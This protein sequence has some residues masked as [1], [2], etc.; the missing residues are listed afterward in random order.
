LNKNLRQQFG[1]TIVELL[2]VIVVIGILAA[3][4]IVAYNGISGRAKVASIQSDLEGSGKQLAIDQVTSGAYP[5]TIAAANGGNGL[6][7]SSGSTYSYVVNN[8]TSPQSYCLSESNGAISYYT[9]STNSVQALG[10]CTTS[11]GL[12]G[13]WPMNGNANDSSGNNMNGIVSGATLTTGQSGTSNGAY[14]FNGTTNYIGFTDT[15]PLNFV[16]NDFAVSGW[17]N[18][19]TLPATATWDDIFSSSYGDWSVGINVT[20]AGVGYLMMTK[21]SQVDAPSSTNPVPQNSWHLVTLDFTY[22]SPASTVSYYLDGVLN[23][24]SSWN[25]SGQGAFT[26]TTKIIGARSSGSS[27]YFHGSI[28]DLR[29]YNRAL[30]SSEITALY[31]KGAQ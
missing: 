2:I 31:S 3:I 26:P 11:Y 8:S 28:D 10:D 16:T 1:F 6:T 27:G 9:T 24:S 18:L 13:W 17:I 29:V 15:T 22:G 23:G 4:T 30:S 5:A 19:T 20:S 7:P 21:L 25:Y 12:V 14:L